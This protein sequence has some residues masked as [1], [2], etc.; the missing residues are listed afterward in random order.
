MN[1]LLTPFQLL[2]V[3]LAGW[4]NRQQQDL[5]EYLKEENRVLREL[6]G[7]Q[8]LRFNDRQRRRLVVRAK[9][10]GRK[11]LR[12]LGTIVTPDTLLRWHRQLIAKK[13]DGSDRRG[14]G[15]PR[16]MVVIRDLVVRFAQEKT[17]VAATR[18]CEACLP[19]LATRS[20]MAPS[21]IF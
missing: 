5:I 18:G 9:A 20:A 14:V 11:A 1:A 13:Y 17:P 21:P 15:R 7:K 3:S 6:H 12:E 19:T 2:L 8:C 10:L 4:I 16:V